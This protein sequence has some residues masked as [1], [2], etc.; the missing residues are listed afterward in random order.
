MNISQMW[1]RTSLSAI[2]S[3]QMKFITSAV[4]SQAQL[5]V[6]PAVAEHALSFQLVQPP[7]NVTAACF[8]A[9]REIFFRPKRFICSCD[10]D[11]PCNGLSDFRPKY[12]KPQLS[13]RVTDRMASPF[14]RIQSAING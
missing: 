7:P 2:R 3:D 5:S 10:V 12:Q 1:S 4:P 11:T 9:A 6:I 14:S 8:F 13:I